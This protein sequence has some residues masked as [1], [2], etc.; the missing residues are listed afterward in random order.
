MYKFKN[1]EDAQSY[2]K[3]QMAKIIG[4]N[5]DTLRRVINGKQEC[6]KLVAYCITKFLDYNSEIENYFIKGE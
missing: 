6:S 1:K 5:P 2:N 3:E 4:L